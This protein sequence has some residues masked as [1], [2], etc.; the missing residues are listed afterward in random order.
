M[1]P[2]VYDRGFLFAK[3]VIILYN[4]NIRENRKQFKFKV[5]V[6]ISSII[7]FLLSAFCFLKI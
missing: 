5:P 7:C 3:I 4:Q 6:A 2:I 1:P